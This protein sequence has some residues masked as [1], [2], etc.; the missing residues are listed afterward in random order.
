MVRAQPRSTRVPIAV[1]LAELAGL[2]LGHHLINLDPLL[3]AVDLALR[4]R[5]QSFGGMSTR[6]RPIHVALLSASDHELV[7]CRDFDA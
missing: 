4:P 3:P 2:R 7:A 6:L 5:V 1:R